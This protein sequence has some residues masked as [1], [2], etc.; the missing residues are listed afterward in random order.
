MDETGFIKRGNHSVGIKW[1][2]SG[3]APKI[4]NYEIGAFLS[5]A[6]AEGHVFLDRRLYPPEE[7]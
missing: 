6:T 2:Y 4:E 7:E 1:Q 5:Y 3:T